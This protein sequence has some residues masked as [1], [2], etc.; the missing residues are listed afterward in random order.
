VA[1]APAEWLPEIEFS[2]AGETARHVGTVV[3]RFLQQ[4]AQDGL[5]RWNVERLGAAEDIARSALRAAGVPDV[6]LDQACTRVHRA[7]TGALAHDKARWVLG[8]HPDAQSELRLTARLDRELIYVAV[9]RTFVDD[10]GTRWIVDYKTGL[11][12]GGDLEAFLDREQERYRP[13]LE[14][15]ARV[16]RGMDGRQV[17]VALY[18]PLLQ[19]WREWAPE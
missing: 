10:S 8:A 12:E 18:F 13:Q 14:R 16:M 3:H 9:D 7:L 1:A 11:H 2:W 6:E 15:Y 17:R 5:A 4:I 19:A